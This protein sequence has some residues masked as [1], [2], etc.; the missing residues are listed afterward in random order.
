MVMFSWLSLFLSGVTLLRPARLAIGPQNSGKS[1]LWEKHLWVFFGIKAD[2]GGLPTQLRSF[3]AAVSNHEIQLFDNLDRVNF[4]DERKDY[5]IYL[6]IMCKCCTGG[7]LSLAKLYENNVDKEYDLRCNLFLSSRINPIP[8]HCS[9]MLRRTI[10]FPFRKPTEDEHRSVENM[11]AEFLVDEPELKLETLV[12]LQNVLRALLANTTE[13]KPI[14]E[15]ASFENFTRR[16]AN[17]EAWDV[18]TIW[19]GLMNNY[20]RQLTEGDAFINWMKCWIGKEGNVGRTLRPGQLYAELDQCYGR[21][22]RKTAGCSN[23]A[24]F[25]KTIRKNLDPLGALGITQIG[26]KSGPTYAFQPK[27][28]VLEECVSCYAET[29][30]LSHWERVYEGE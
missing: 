25:G 9:D 3:I 8:S 6:D 20:Q 12:R 27:P 19:R 15:M 1:T 5:P 14:S 4:N 17:Y 16:V 22:F 26:N 11:R 7:K 24:L 28:E 23:V 10:T 29:Q 21:N 2:S 30:H 13:Y 18:E